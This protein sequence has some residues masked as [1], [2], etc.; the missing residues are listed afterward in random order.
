MFNTIVLP[1]ICMLQLQ[2]VATEGQRGTNR[3]VFYAVE[4][5][6]GVRAARDLAEHHGLEFISRVSP[7]F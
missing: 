1:F 4:M 7:C 6:G 5:D 2:L 3:P